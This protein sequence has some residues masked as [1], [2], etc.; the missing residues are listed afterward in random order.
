MKRVG[1]IVV[2]VCG[3][4]V[5]VS[6]TA[7]WISA[8]E[9]SQPVAIARPKPSPAPQARIVVAAAPAPVPSASAQPDLPAN[10]LFAVSDSERIAAAIAAPEDQ[11]VVVLSSDSDETYSL[12]ISL[13]DLHTTHPKMTEIVTGVNAED[14]STPVWNGNR[15]LYYEVEDEKCNM[16][17][18]GRCGIY[19]LDP[20]TGQSNELLDHSTGGLAVSSDG[21]FLAFWDY[22]TGDKLTVFDI[23]HKKTV[24]E[25]ERQTHTADDLI[26]RDMVFS[27]DGKSLLARTYEQGKY[28]LK[29][30]DLQNGRVRTMSPDSSGPVSAPDGVY[31]VESH[32]PSDNG[33]VAQIWKRVAQTGAEAEQIIADFPYNSIL[34]SGGQQRWASAF[35]DKG[36]FLF[37]TKT[38]FAE[39][40]GNQCS[41][42][43]VMANG[44]A[45]YATNTTISLDPQICGTPTSSPGY[46]PA[47]LSKLDEMK[48][49]YVA[50][51][52]SAAGAEQA[53][54][55]FS[56]NRAA[57]ELASLM[58]EASRR[59]PKQFSALE[60]E[61]QSAGIDIR[62]CTV[63]SLWE[64]QTTGYKEYLALLP[65]GPVADEAWWKA[66]AEG[67]GDFE[68]SADNLE[69]NVALYQDFLKR[70]P[71][72]SHA[73]EAKHQV[74]TNQQLL[75][76]LHK[77]EPTQPE[78]SAKSGSNQ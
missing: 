49:L 13:V 59:D 20:I 7:A 22:S 73:A 52:T 17:S 56:L 63:G 68:P 5:A 32:M 9:H 64:A 15:H 78:Q 29:E 66:N 61:T 41:L 77:S 30:F 75:L 40:L 2:L 28:P 4:A 31:F 48:K 69:A 50:T 54:T 72:S 14:F 38:S 74:E 18:R 55:W 23:F 39:P 45:I 67:C 1:I 46:T 71:D 37:D 33:N 62:Y 58:S 12:K 24:R 35:S 26:V 27:A 53:G 21:K 11:R 16:S 76:Q 8:R 34:S 25:W 36:A 43:T 57:D 65:N 47:M 42:A 10:V 6:L 44:R 51:A 3:I 70:F 19:D 60:K